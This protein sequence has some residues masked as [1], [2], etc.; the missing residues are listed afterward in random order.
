MLH[1]FII[2]TLFYFAGLNMIKKNFLNSSIANIIFFVK[3]GYY[4]NVK[5]KL[6]IY[7]TLFLFLFLC[8]LVNNLMGLVPYSYAI[9]TS[10]IFNLF[11]V[12]TFFIGINLIGIIY[13]K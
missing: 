7:I 1:L 8:I 12:L 5:I 4:K 3:D 10:L 13:H 2:I 6:D 9:T 11:I